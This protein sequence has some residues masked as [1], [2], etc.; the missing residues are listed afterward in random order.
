MK[1]TL[2]GLGLLAAAT[3]AFAGKPADGSGDTGSTTSLEYA[4]IGNTQEV[5]YNDVTGRDAKTLQE[6]I[7][8]CQLDFGA[9]ARIATS[10]EV[11]T[12]LFDGTEYQFPA[13]ELRAVIWPV[14]T[15][16]YTNGTSSY[17][18]DP[19]LNVLRKAGKHVA[20]YKGAFTEADLYNSGSSNILKSFVVSC[21]APQ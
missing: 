6:M 20:G 14:D 2:I 18:Y 19:H 15:F 11:A 1:K 21:S 8:E 17:F 3:T 12:A 13:D 5:F 10:K 9:G 16:P 4:Y 7:A